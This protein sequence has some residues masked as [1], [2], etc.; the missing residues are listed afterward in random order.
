MNSFF[1]ILL[2]VTFAF[3]FIV[4][5]T[6]GYVI[7]RINKND[8]VSLVRSELKSINVSQ[9]KV[10]GSEKVSPWK[11]DFII[12]VLIRGLPQ[13][14]EMSISCREAIDFELNAKGLSIND[15]VIGDKRGKEVITVLSQHIGH[16]KAAAAYN[17][18][19]INRILFPRRD[20]EKRFTVAPYRN[21]VPPDI[22]FNALEKYVEYSN[23][24]PREYLEMID[25]EVDLSLRSLK[26]INA[27]SSLSDLGELKMILF[28]HE[29]HLLHLIQNGKQTGSSSLLADTREIDDL[30][31][32]RLNHKNYSLIVSKGNDVRKKLSRYIE[33]R[34]QVKKK[35]EKRSRVQK[36]S[37]SEKLS[38][39]YE[40]FKKLP[41]EEKEKLLK[42][43]KTA[44]GDF[45]EDT[46]TLVE[47]MASLETNS[48]E[49]GIKSLV[50]ILKKY[51][52][53][54]KDSIYPYLRF[55]R[56]DVESD[57]V[58]K[59][60]YV[61]NNLHEF[62]ETGEGSHKSELNQDET[63][64]MRMLLKDLNLSAKR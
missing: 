11:R 4:L 49:Y 16:F 36:E 43:I 29:G 21:Q 33:R 41:V 9:N 42:V 12:G 61:V 14:K 28:F 37:F 60:S 18:V 22:F 45:F 38:R 31:H 51:S 64:K 5:M 19:L 17:I 23:C 2:S 26:E 54:V 34:L 63:R 47:E 46:D 39:S 52:I 53:F 32:G 7:Y 3:V 48:S 57:V 6:G 27:D 24:L 15:I 44:Y 58:K 62:I 8:P 56:T 10:E 35:R 20:N 40:K 50:I 13:L 1:K 30:L 55:K 25:K 59:L